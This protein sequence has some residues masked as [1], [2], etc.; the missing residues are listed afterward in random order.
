MKKLII[1]SILSICAS[2]IRSQ[3]CE[4]SNEVKFPGFTKNY[5]RFDF[6]DSL[7][8]SSFIPPPKEVS[9]EKDR[10]IFFIHGLGGN[11]DA[12]ATAMDAVKIGLPD[13]TF[14]ARKTIN[15][16]MTY[17]EEGL[18]PMTVCAS[19]VEDRISDIQNSNQFS[20]NDIDNTM[21]ICH[22]QG[23]IVART[24]NF[25]AESLPHLRLYNGLVFFTSPL[26]GAEI[27]QS[28][29]DGLGTDLAAWSSDLLLRPLI[30]K[31]IDNVNWIFPWEFVNRTITDKLTNILSNTVIS[32]SN[33]IINDLA[34]QKQTNSF[35][36]NSQNLAVLKDYETDP[37]REF[38]THRVAF[39]SE[40]PDDGD[41]I[42]CTLNYFVNV[43]PGFDYFQAN[44]DIGPGTWKDNID[45]I[46]EEYDN[47][48]GIMYQKQLG[49]YCH[50]W[51]GYLHHWPTCDEFHKTEHLFIRANEF[52]EGANDKWR[53]IIGATKPEIRNQCKVT[54]YSEDYY[55][56][57]TCEQDFYFPEITNQNVCGQKALE[58]FD[59][60]PSDYSCPDMLSGYS[61]DIVPYTVMVE[62]PSDGVVTLESQA[63]I[64][65]KTLPTQFLFNSSHM[66][67][68][69][70]ENLKNSLK[71]LFNNEIEDNDSGK[72]FKT[73]PR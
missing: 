32:A 14:P 57:N 70:D 17:T 6:I 12:W 68:R 66:Q 51:W 64:N 58:L 41:L 60:P 39:A 26:N 19:K 20:Q 18:V 24:M 59:S 67:I 55:I 23:G 46:Q 45:D 15:R 42:W 21:L 53:I 11:E 54:L 9:S 44:A 10:L 62:S 49:Q 72:W 71:R 16:T 31:T 22:S 36:P 47:Q 56:A 4:Y 29:K 40:E 5:I 25:R 28:A 35:L 3:N 34:N 50:T 7:V 37:N 43:P 27:L 8:D 1:I 2:V 48:R 13:G 65:D 52:F 73:A 38:K 63:A 61:S 69:N 33:F 30:K